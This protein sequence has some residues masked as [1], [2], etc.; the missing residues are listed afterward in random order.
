[1]LT[2]EDLFNRVGIAMRFAKDEEIYGEGEAAD[3]VYRMISG[4]VRTSRFMADGRRPIGDFYYK[5]DIFGLELG[6]THEMAAEALSDCAVM[7]ARREAIIQLGGEKALQ[8]LVL[9]STALALTNAR[10]H[11][12]LLVRKSAS[13]RVASFLLGMARRGGDNPIELVMGRQDIAD[14]LGLT[15]ETVSRMITQLQGQGVVRFEGC[16]RFRIC[17]R[18]ALLELAAAA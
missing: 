8:A 12:S 3:H 1:M 14:Y 4:T 6:E 15:I 2:T 18:D 16:R 5:G 9:E 10:E 11:L 17:N 7:V 13:E